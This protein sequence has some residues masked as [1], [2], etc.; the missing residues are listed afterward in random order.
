MWSEEG[1]GLQAVVA[2]SGGGRL[3]IRYVWLVQFHKKEKRRERLKRFMYVCMYVYVCEREMSALARGLETD[4]KRT[5]REGERRHGCTLAFLLPLEVSA[6]EDA[7][8][9]RHKPAR[10]TREKE[11]TVLFCFIREKEKTK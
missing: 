11:R 9:T 5:W 3:S 2:A 1:R 6:R 4:D 10:H 8:S 7:P